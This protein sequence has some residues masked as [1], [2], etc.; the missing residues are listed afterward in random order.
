MGGEAVVLVVALGNPDLA[1]DGVG[2]RVATVLRERDDAR[3]RVVEIGARGASALLDALGGEGGLIVVDG[4]MGPGLDPGAVVD[5]DCR[6][7]RRPRFARDAAISSHAISLAEQLML[8]DRLGML[9]A[10]VRVVGVSVASVRVG[11][12]MAPAVRD[13]VPEAVARVMAWADRWSGA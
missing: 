9:P 11:E 2:A 1:D 7:P 12:A 3:L 10:R 5:V 4:V 6:D 13:A 8:A